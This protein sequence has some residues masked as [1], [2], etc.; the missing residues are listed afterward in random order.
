MKKD[1]IVGL[2]VNVSEIDIGDYAHTR[3]VLESSRVTST[4]A[5]VVSLAPWCL[6]CV[7]ET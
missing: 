4:V 5:G 1:S 6:G 7:A 3:T 2:R